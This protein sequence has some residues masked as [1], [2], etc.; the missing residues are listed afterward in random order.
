MDFIPLSL[1]TLRAETPELV[2]LELAASP[3]FLN[4]YTVAG[5]YVQIQFGE[6]KPGFFAIANSP[7]DTRKK[8]RIELL[9]KRGSPLTDALALSH[10]EDSLH[11]SL[12]Q[13]RGFSISAVAQTHDIYVIGAGSGIA[14][15][16]ALIQEFLT[17][18]HDFGK[19]TLL[20]GARTQTLIPYPNEQSKWREQGIHVTHAISGKSEDKPS[21]IFDTHVGHVQDVLRNLQK[22]TPVISENSAAFVC[23][24]KAMVEDLKKLLPELGTAANRIFQ[25]F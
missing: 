16:R 19:I 23:G 3:E 20:Y 24:P 10:C 18:R 5:Q 14:P 7:D 15:L 6:M 2:H 13:G 11:V 8:A 1:T 9:I 12:P 21:V 17:H 22:Q 25:N 4:A